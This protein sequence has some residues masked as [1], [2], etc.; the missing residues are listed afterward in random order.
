MSD[1]T[2]V[3]ATAPSHRSAAQTGA[4]VAKRAEERKIRDYDSK[5]LKDTYD[6]PGDFHPI[7][8][9]VHGTWGS[10]AVEALNVLRRA[11]KDVMPERAA[12]KLMQRCKQSIAIELQRGNAVLQ[13]VGL[14]RARS[15]KYNLLCEFIPPLPRM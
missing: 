14:D 4:A 1:T 5:V 6:C 2:R 15:S 12:D 9:E 8:Y 10:G 11:A 13:R 3:N 7:A